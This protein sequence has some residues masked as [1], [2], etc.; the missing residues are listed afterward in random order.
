MTALTAYLLVLFNGGPA[1]SGRQSTERVPDGYGDYLR[2]ADR[3]DMIPWDP[4]TFER[5]AGAGEELL[6][7]SGGY[8]TVSEMEEGDVEMV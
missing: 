5:L 1:R 7:D 3:R 6:F 2:E 4:A 8:E